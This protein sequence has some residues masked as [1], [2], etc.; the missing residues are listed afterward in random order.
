MAWIELHQTLREHKKLFACADALNLSRIEMIGTLVSL[1]LWA[2]DNAQDGSLE[3][4]SDRTVAR[5]CD[6]PEKKAAKLMEALHKYGWLDRDGEHYVIHDWY[7]Y[8]G[9][10]MERRE[11]DRKRKKISVSK[12]LDFHGNS[13]GTP[14]EVHGN[15]HATVPYRTVQNNTL[16]IYSGNNTAG[17]AP[18]AGESPP[19]DGKLFT[20]FWESYPDKCDREGAW[21]AWCGLNPDARLAG[22]IMASLDAWKLS[23]QWLDQNGKFIPRA[24]KWLAQ[25]HWQNSPAPA[26]QPVNQPGCTWGCGNLGEA[27]LAAIRRTMAEEFDEEDV[28]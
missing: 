2:L 9:K 20:A 15:S 4:V 6:F 11:K 17:G 22:T 27:E 12:P 19:N 3:G 25:G 24:A 28:K 26:K 8:A 13:N 10:L 23:A 1:W 16:P 14:E 21:E 5:V 18:A 7:D